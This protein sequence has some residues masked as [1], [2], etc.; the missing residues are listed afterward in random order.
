L[1]SQVNTNKIIL[2]FLDPMALLKFGFSN[3]GFVERTNT[4]DFGTHFY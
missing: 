2:N 1:G 3:A 4:M